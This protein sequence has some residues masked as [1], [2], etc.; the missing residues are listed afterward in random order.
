MS[1]KS[2]GDYDLEQS[3]NRQV[4]V[5]LVSILF[6]MKLEVY[7]YYD[8]ERK[9]FTYRTLNKQNNLLSDEM[10]AFISWRLSSRLEGVQI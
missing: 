9:K 8:F 6:L 7:F 3:I 5:T 1:K 2:S 4:E 10:I